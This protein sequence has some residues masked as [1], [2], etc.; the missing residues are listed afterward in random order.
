MHHRHPLVDNPHVEDETELWG[1][2]SFTRWN[3]CQKL[4]QNSLP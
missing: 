4:C 1:I 2:I 3:F